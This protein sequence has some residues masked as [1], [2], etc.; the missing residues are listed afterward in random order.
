MSQRVVERLKTENGIYRFDKPTDD[1]LDRVVE[2][3]AVA[4]GPEAGYRQISAD[5]RYVLGFP[6]QTFD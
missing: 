6:F 3:A 2:V 5:L 4:N 1:D